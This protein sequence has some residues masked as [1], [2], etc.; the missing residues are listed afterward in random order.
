MSPTLSFSSAQINVLALSIFL[1]RALSIKDDDGNPVDCIL[2]D[3]PVQTM[4]EINIFGLVDL[5][6]N[7]FAEKQ[8]ILS[9]HEDEI[10]RYLRYKFKKSGVKTLNI[11]VR[12]TLHERVFSEIV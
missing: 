5:L 3:D 12:D 8:L 10:S 7:E 2:I 6:R 9:T 11:D 1:A 4:D